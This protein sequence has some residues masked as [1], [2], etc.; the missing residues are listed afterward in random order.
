MSAS[1]ELRPQHFAWQVE[2]NIATITLNRPERKNPLTFDSYRELTETFHKLQ[3]F[4]SIKAVAITGAGGNFS[5][6]GDV[7]DIIGPLVEMKERKQPERLL[8]FTRM[9]GDLVKAMRA[10]P[11]PIIAAIDGVCA[12]AGAIIAMASDI[13]FGTPQS[14][15]A[16]LFVRVGLSGADMGACVILPRIIGYGRAA[17]LLYSGR[18]M[19][20]AEAERWGFYNRVVASE[21]LMAEATQFARQLADGPTVAHAATKRCLHDEWSMSIGEAID[22][23][24]QVQA[25]CMQTEDFARAY[26]AFA[27]KQA[28]KFEGN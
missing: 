19:S 15:V 27:A 24:A 13:R 23:E 17:E 28:P 14:R 11:Q 26:R 20:S 2:D 22:L 5:S 6:G 21:H 25:T 10:C 4:T 7:H 8:A 9:T 12:G 16:F 18:F 3:E 1:P